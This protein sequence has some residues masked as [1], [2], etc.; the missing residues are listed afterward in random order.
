MVL[1]LF[2]LHLQ[3]WRFSSSYLL[4]AAMGNL[5]VLWRAA[6][7]AAHPSGL[8]LSPLVGT[9][10]WKGIQIRFFFYFLPSEGT[11]SFCTPALLKLTPVSHIAPIL[12]CSLERGACWEL[13]LCCG[14]LGVLSC[15]TSPHL[16]FSNLLKF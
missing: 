10:V 12:L 9:G 7:S 14:L 11:I 3:G 1:G 5:H 13:L 4:L 8:C 16:V 2:L 6:G 15:H